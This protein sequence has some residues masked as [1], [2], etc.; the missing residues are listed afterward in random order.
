M[1]L[2]QSVACAGLLGLLACSAFSLRAA[3]AAYG[4][5]RVSRMV[6]IQVAGT[7]AGFSPDGKHLIF[8]RREKSGYYQLYLTDLNANSV[9]IAMTKGRTG[10]GQ[11]DNGNGVIYPDPAYP[12]AAFISE[13]NPHYLSTTPPSGQVPLGDSGVGLFSN[14]W[15][16]DGVNFSQQTNVPMKQTASDGL[17]VY[18]TVNPRFSPDGSMIVWTERY[19]NGGPLNWGYWRLKAADVVKS[20]V[21]GQFRLSIANPRVLFTPANGNYVTAMAFASS[22]T[23]LVAGNLDGQHQ[24]GMDLYLLDINTGSYTNLTNS[25]LSW[26]EGSCIA[27]SGKIVYMSNKDSAYTVDF[28]KDWVG[29][30][31]TREYYLMNQDGTGQEQLTY[32]NTPGT[33]EYTGWRAVPIV[34]N[35][36]PDG[37]TI[38][39][40][41]GHDYGN[42]TQAF[43]LWEV[44]LI[45]LKSPL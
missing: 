2:Y 41:I 27:P 28:N 32:F 14:L 33:A 15:F 22:T 21:P 26:E 20:S 43:L 39:A 19:E 40:T 13:A 11:L 12:Y 10:I 23:L 30:P 24:Y 45:Q 1:K 16:T 5:P 29:Q 7:R 25:P 9:P 17:P 4:N 8:D 18:A 38:A 35:V 34:C 36:S 3:S 44:W 42:A 37:M 31:L 6:R